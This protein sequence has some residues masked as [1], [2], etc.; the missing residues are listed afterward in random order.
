MTMGAQK[1]IAPRRAVPANNVNLP[2]RPTQFR[3]E[4]VEQIE[5][6]GIVGQNCARTMVAQVM[7]EFGERLWNVAI[8]AAVNN[9][10][11]FPCVSVEKPQPI[12]WLR[13]N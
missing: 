7:I 13:R 5:N 11:M 9:I 4:I 10:E 3:I 2:V 1:F 6:P 12:F 8:S